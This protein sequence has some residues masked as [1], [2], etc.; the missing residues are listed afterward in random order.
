[1]TEVI[2]SCNLQ[3]CSIKPIRR[4]HVVRCSGGAFRFISSPKL[5]RGEFCQSKRSSNLN[6]FDCMRLTSS[7]SKKLDMV[8]QY[9]A[10]WNE[11]TL[12][13]IFIVAIPS[14][15][16]KRIQ[17]VH[18][19][20]FHNAQGQMGKNRHVICYF[21]YSIFFIFLSF[22]LISMQFLQIFSSFFM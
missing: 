17:P 11:N 7:I 18:F 13:A 9:A 10:W 16:L 20:L 22:I 21:H 1:M 14:S 6:R 3:L 19:H 5:K 2:A 15:F 8:F 12:S 4:R